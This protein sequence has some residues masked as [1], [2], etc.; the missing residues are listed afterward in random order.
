VILDFDESFRASNLQAVKDTAVLPAD[1]VRRAIAI[2]VFEGG[3]K[4]YPCEK[5]AREATN[6][7]LN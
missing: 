4:K 2:A 6:L 3:G 7:L 5:E 1:K